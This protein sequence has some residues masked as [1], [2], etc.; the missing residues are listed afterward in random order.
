MSNE[1]REEVFE[2]AVELLGYVG[3][4]ASVYTGYSGRGMFG[5]ITEGIVADCSGAL[6]GW[7]V[8]TAAREMGLEDDEVIR[9]LPK[10][11]DSMGRD[12]IFY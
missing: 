4:D 10:R 1:K 2:Q 3:A 6:V 5:D 11:T 9:M 8:T 12:T 7:A